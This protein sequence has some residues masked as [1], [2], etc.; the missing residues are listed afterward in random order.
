M[1]MKLMTKRSTYFRFN[2]QRVA[3]GGIAAVKEMWNGLGKVG[4]KNVKDI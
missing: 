4:V 2:S 1:H 3:D